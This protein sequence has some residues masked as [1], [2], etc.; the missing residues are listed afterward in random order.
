MS[1]EPTLK[2]SSSSSC[3]YVALAWESVGVFVVLGTPWA[4]ILDLATGVVR[5]TF[6]AEYIG[7]SSLDIAAV[8]LAADGHLLLIA[9]TKRVWV[10]DKRLIPVLRYEPRYLLSGV[11]R[12]IDGAVVIPEYDFGS[13]DELIEQ[14]IGFQLE[15]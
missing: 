8:G 12:L 1:P 14:T 4:V 2:Y 6:S 5:Q 10:I 3:D 13:D 9:S 7:K 15:S 11:P